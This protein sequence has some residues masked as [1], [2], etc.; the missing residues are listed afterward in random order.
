[1]TTTAR[2][3]DSDIFRFRATPN[4]LIIVDDSGSMA[5]T[6]GG[7]DVGDLD[8]HTRSEFS[9]TGTGATSLTGPG[10]S[11][12]IDVAW[13]VLYQLLNADA[14][15]PS[16]LTTPY[17][18][19]RS[20]VSP[21]SSPSNGYKY[22][23]DL[24]TADENALKVRLGLMI[25]GDA[26]T[27]GG[28]NNLQVPVAIGGTDAN[29]PPFSSGKTYRD[30]WQQIKTNYT[31]GNNPTP[32]SRS[33]EAARNT[34]F[35]NARSGD[36][37]NACRKKFVILVTDGEDTVG[38]SASASPTVPASSGSGAVP[39][40]YVGGSG[41]DEPTDPNYGRLGNP[42]TGTSTTW[43]YF[44]PDGSI[45]QYR[46]EGQELREHRLG[47]EPGLPDEP[48][49]QRPDL[50]RRRGDDGRQHRERPAAPARP[51]QGPPPHGAAAGDRPYL[52]GI[53]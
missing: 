19:L 49:R 38:S 47:E 36:G 28:F 35:V 3:D 32:M 18:T 9:G 8:G 44:N 52:R 41:V 21:D 16:G 2:A 23:Q 5:R 39:T 33:L 34:F 48:R 40:Y 14:S 13:R 50:R 31:P 45:R 22:N 42:P 53:Q 15:V 1:M 6:Y 37:S 24:T 12:R 46:A 20:H 51:P 11:S 17:P 25:Y 43:Q 29:Q 7:T 4:V 27:Y 30:V 10:A 26:G